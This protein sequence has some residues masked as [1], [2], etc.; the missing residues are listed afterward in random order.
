MAKDKDPKNK[1][2]RKPTGAW[3]AFAKVFEALVDKFGWPGVLVIFVMHMIE[4][5]AT[6]EQRRAL[7]D[8]Y[9]LGRNIRSAYPIMVMGVIF[10]AVLF[11]QRYYYRKQAD[12]M[13]SELERIGAD[14]SAWQEKALGTRLHHTSVVEGKR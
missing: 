11:A 7:I 14:K 1:P 4:F 13:E 6:D 12:L 3:L 8:M 10:L 5:R 9:L 2:G